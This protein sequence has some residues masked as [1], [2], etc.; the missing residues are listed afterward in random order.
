MILSLAFDGSKITL[1]ENNAIKEKFGS[2]PIGNHTG[3]DL[4]EYSRATFQVCYDVLNPIAMK[5]ILGHGS[6][7]EV[8]LALDSSAIKIV[9]KFIHFFIV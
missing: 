3:K 4:G 9:D 2:K 8:D 1:P 6:S 5:S 7:Y